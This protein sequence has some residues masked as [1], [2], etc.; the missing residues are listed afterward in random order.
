MKLLE[1]I[2]V[3]QALEQAQTLKFV[4]ITE[5]SRVVIGKTPMDINWDELIEARFFDHDTEIRI[6]RE[7]SELRARS[8]ILQDDMPY[9]EKQYKKLQG[10]L[11]SEISVREYL[12]FDEDGQ[13]GV[14]A[15][16][17]YDWRE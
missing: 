8:V 5:L 13:A 7:N 11:G 10:N 14:S 6:F 3:E 12:T 1:P 17:L 2:S 15:V 16:C 4:M 9:I